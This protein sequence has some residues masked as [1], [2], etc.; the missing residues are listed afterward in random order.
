M[1]DSAILVLAAGSSSRM[2]GG[3]KLL[4]L[5]DGVALLAERLET[6]RATGHP[7][8]VTL[9]PRASYPERWALVSRWITAIEVLDASEGMA[10]SLKAGIAALPGETRSVL[11][12]LADMPD[13]TQ[14]DLEHMFAANDGAHI[15]RGTSALGVPGHPVVFQKRDFADL[16]ALSGDQ[17]AKSLMNAQKSRLT[18]VTLPEQHALTDLDTPEA[19]A[20]W[21][22]SR[23][24]RSSVKS[25]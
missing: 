6:A 1:S 10:Q 14:D 13:I 8:Y 20:K 24:T 2:R 7:V 22:T 15:L 16:L 18:H 25:R 23:E 21:R 12:M 17:G 9:P 11:V 3:D 4:E 5:V 19:W